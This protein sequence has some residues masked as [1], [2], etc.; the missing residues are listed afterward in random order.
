MIRVSPDD[1]WEH[2]RRSGRAGEADREQIQTATHGSFDGWG[3]PVDDLCDDAEA[4]RIGNRGRLA[5][6]RHFVADLSPPAKRR[7]R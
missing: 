2:T 5:F 6:E 7:R 1:G 4:E 3:I